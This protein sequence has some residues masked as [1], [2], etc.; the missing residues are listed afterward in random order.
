MP[1]AG[2]F[3]E[4]TN[5]FAQIVDVIDSERGRWDKFLEEKRERDRKRT[6]P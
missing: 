4:Q 5:Q 3:E 2:G 6:K 1:Y